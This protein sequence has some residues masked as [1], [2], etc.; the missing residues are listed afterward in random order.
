M[1]SKLGLYHPF[2]GPNGQYR[3]LSQWQE[4]KGTISLD[5][6]GTLPTD[7]IKESF[8]S[9]LPRIAEDGSSGYMKQK[10]AMDW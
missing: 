3:Q 9:S 10:S 4:Q 6:F 8:Y 5:T 1:I 2:G 7:V